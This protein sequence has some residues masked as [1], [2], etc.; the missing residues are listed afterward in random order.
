[1]RIYLKMQAIMARILLA[2]LDGKGEFENLLSQHEV[3]YAETLNSAL[4]ITEQD[5]F[6]AIICGVAF[7]ES[8]MFDFLRAITADEKFT[9][10]PFICCRVTDSELINAIFE[11]LQVSCRLLGAEFVDFHRMKK[12]GRQS[13]FLDVLDKALNGRK[14]KSNSPN[15]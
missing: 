13:E 12:E 4:R 9:N 5:S 1:M 7:D 11:N 6:D 15:P 10:V 8:R 2:V 3:I 14:S